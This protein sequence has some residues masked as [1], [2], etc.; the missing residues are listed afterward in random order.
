M[1]VVP[2]KKRKP[3]RQR[4][5]R[6]VG[7][8]PK[9]PWDRWFDGSIWIIKKGGDRKSGWPLWMDGRRFAAIVY[10]TAKRRDVRVELS[11]DDVEVL[12]QAFPGEP[13]PKREGHEWKKRSSE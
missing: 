8:P 4:K 6:P 11:Y 12:L 5:S 13:Y 1:T 10:V 9:Y 2:P 7:K 3:G